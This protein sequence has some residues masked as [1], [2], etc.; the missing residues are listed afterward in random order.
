MSVANSGLPFT[1]KLR[2][3]PIRLAFAM[4][5]NKSQGQS[6][7]EVF[8]YLPEPVFSHGQLYTAFSRV[9]AAQDLRVFVPNENAKHGNVVTINVVYGELLE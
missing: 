5:I 8:V 2:Q 6:L 3:F 4:T 9:G 1:L 7:A